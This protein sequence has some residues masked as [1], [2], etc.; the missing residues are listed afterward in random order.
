M[1]EAVPPE[2]V[3]RRGINRNIHHCRTIGGQCRLYRAA[4]IGQTVDVKPGRAI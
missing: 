2:A 3:K 1:R 4:N